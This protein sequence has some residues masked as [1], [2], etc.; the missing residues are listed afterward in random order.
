M[1]RELLVKVEKHIPMV[2]LSVLVFWLLSAG[3][4]YLAGKMIE[5]LVDEKIEYSI[6]FEAWMIYGLSTIVFAM[7]YLC[8]WNSKKTG[9][10]LKVCLAVILLVFA[11]VG[12]FITLILS[13]ETKHRFSEASIFQ[14]QH[15]K[16]I[17][18]CLLLIVVLGS[19]ILSLSDKIKLPV[20]ASPQGSAPNTPTSGENMGQET[21]HDLAHHH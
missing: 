7:P 11:A 14:T 19:V 20:R 4:A 15:C 8:T 1:E 16:P 9:G 13:I 6:N 21:Q 12:S 3:T 18:A 10:Q 5:H 2:I 17:V